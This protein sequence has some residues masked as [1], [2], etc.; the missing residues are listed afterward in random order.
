MDFSPEKGWMFVLVTAWW[1]CRRFLIK[2][3]ASWDQGLQVVAV[4]YLLSGV[5]AVS[6]TNHWDLCNLVISGQIYRKYN[7]FNLTV[8]TSKSKYAYH[9]PTVLHAACCMKNRIT[10][11]TWIAACYQDKAGLSST[12]SWSAAYYQD[13]AGLSSTWSAAYCTIPR[14]SKPIK[15][16]ECRILPRYSR[17]IKYLECCILPR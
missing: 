10:T 1:H 12:W 8:H 4:F 15:Y 17:P 5:K 7:F 13:T 9:V 11:S 6:A 14:Y 2:L 16:L 3:G